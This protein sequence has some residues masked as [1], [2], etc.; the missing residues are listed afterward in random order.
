[1]DDLEHIASLEGEEFEKAVK[2]AQLRRSDRDFAERV[3]H[4]DRSLAVA[5]FF[6]LV[7]LAFGLLTAISRLTGGV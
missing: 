3:R 6:G 1:M 2:L 7:G 5:I 4:S